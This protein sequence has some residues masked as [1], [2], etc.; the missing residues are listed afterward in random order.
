MKRAFIPS[1]HRPY[2]RG[3][4][5]CSTESKIISWDTRQRRKLIFDIAQ[6]KEVFDGLNTKWARSILEE[7]FPE[8][9]QE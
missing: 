8:I 9:I 1:S 3:T 6:G 7:M 2:V 5:L 4:K